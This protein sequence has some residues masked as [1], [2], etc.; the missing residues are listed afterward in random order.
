[1]GRAMASD[2][3]PRGKLEYAAA[4]F[5]LVVLGFLVWSAFDPTI[6]IPPSEA[7]DVLMDLGDIIDGIV[8]PGGPL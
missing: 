3:P 4:A 1:M 5:V 7:A 8:D 2:K 6:N